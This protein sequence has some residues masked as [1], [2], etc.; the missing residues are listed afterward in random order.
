MVERLKKILLAT[1][2]SVLLLSV[3][4]QT[5]PMK[6]AEI[7]KT[8]KAVE[9]SEAV[10][11]PD[12][13]WN[14]NNRCRNTAQIPGVNGAIESMTL[15]AR[16]LNSEYYALIY[17]SDG[18]RVTGFFGR[19]KND[20]LHPAIIYN[21]G[22]YREYG[23]LEGWE[24]VPFVEAG[25]VAVASQYRGNAGSEGREEF[26]G[27]DVNDVLNLLPLLKQLPYV[28][29]ERIGMM[30]HSRGGMVTYL[31]LK[32]ET[33]EGTHDIKAAATVGGVAD[34]FML[35]KDHPSFIS[36]VGARPEDDPALYEARSATHW[37]EFINA[38]LLIQ[39]G[40]ADRI[41]SVEQSRRL[42]EAL[43]ESG[44]TVELV[45]YPGEDH[46]L[47]EH[48]GGMP[49]ALTWFQRYLGNLGE[50]HS[51]ESHANAIREVIVGFKNGTL[52]NLL[53][54][55]AGNLSGIRVALY[56]GSG[57]WQYDIVAMSN[58]FEWMGCSVATVRGDDIKSGRLDNFDVLAWPGGYMPGYWEEVGLEGKSK[59]QDFVSSGGGY[60]GICGGA[61]YA[62][63]YWVW[64][65]WKAEGELDLDLF[66]GVAHGPINEI[67]GEY[68]MTRIDIVDRT[69][70]ITDSLPECMQIL[71]YD[72]PYL[73]PYEDA[74]VTILG[75]Y[76][77]AGT[78]AIVA[79]QYGNG[80]VFLTG[81]HPEVEEDSDRDGFALDIGYWKTFSDEGSDWPLLL[82]AMKWLTQLRIEKSV[83]TAT[84]SGTAFFSLDSGILE[85]PTVVAEATLP[86]AGKPDL[87]FPH[88]FFSFD[89]IGLTEGQTVTVTI[90][91]P[92]NMPVGTQYWKCQGD[93]WYQIPIGDDDGD[94]VII[95]TLAD[96]GLGD[97]DGV[98]NE[99]I[100]DQ[101]GPG[102]PQFLPTDLNK[103]GI[104]DIFDVVIVATAFGSEPRDPDWN[105][106]ADINND[107]IV[108]IF[109]V[110][111]IAKDFGKTA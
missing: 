102:H 65:G 71:Y 17:W 72:G 80:S 56:N 14:E 18:L 40:E 83:E 19:P 16:T 5:I 10:Y 68:N 22:G 73:Q 30:G 63:D 82:E 48:H 74:N 44:K 50:D 2:I 46:E 24:I 51:F 111:T 86:T 55:R 103:D 95:I 53:L 62:C 28:D 35:C 76:D 20:G 101:G 8:G 3:M 109:D 33:L 60:M 49:E 107:S 87:V 36:M 59:I 67:A 32:Q 108:D 97:D 104:V 57:A 89:M 94:N 91:L 9:S 64:Q 37:P 93:T 96:G 25:Y 58:L 31:A 75:T 84:G 70:P 41:V 106:V 85:G 77:M 29:P 26:G 54:S 21:R 92:L 7:A 42:A 13:E 69:H 78:P 38:P 4:A 61:Y 45:T 98:A 39:H 110:V 52:H 105:P 79:F 1:L 27:A 12:S 99:V 6:S 47:S 11:L 34:L 66:P 90:T 100:V 81:P 15:I 43:K 88:G 23:A